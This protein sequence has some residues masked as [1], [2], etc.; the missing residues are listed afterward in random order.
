MAHERTLKI[1]TNLKAYSWEAT[2]VLTLAAFA[3]EFGDFWLLVELE[4]SN[5]NNLSKSLAILKGAPNLTSTAEILQARKT[6]VIALNDL[7]KD[8]LELTDIIFQLE[9]LSSNFPIEI[10]EI[11][12]EIDI[13]WIMISVIACGSKVAILTSTEE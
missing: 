10:A 9:N 4:K 12:K 3:S 11:P 5:H 13:Y 1:L 2:A 8:T 7:I 6:A